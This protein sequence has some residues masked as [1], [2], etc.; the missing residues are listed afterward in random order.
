MIKLWQDKKEG[1]ISWLVLLGLLLAVFL[2]LLGPVLHHADRYRFELGRDARALQQ[3]RAIEAVQ[4][5]IAQVQQ[6][7]QQR[8]LQ[9]WV[10]TGQN[11]SDISLDV[12]RRVSDWLSVTQV[13]R[14]TPVRVKADN[15]YEG[16]GV[17]V[18][19]TSSME[20]LLAVIQQI[21]QSRPLLAVERMRVA[22]VAQ[23][24]TR[25]QPEPPQNVTVQMTIHTY[26]ATGGEP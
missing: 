19:F 12:Q 26:V 21:Q 25:N 23:R 1:V 6:D 10:Y 18:H 16:L 13:Q 14:I 4:D 7:Y 11:A 22:P 2:L 15:N 8:G 5:E 24:R 17:Q 9:G 3:L 20:E